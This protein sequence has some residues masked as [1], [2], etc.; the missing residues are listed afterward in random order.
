M[1][2]ADSETEQGRKSSERQGPTGAEDRG[3]MQ[4]QELLSVVD[5]DEV[6]TKVVYK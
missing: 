6:R 3:S 5:K 1:E 4:Q 2:S